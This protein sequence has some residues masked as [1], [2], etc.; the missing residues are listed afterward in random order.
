[1]TK[2]DQK[3]A[4]ELKHMTNGASGEESSSKEADGTDGAAPD[5]D[6]EFGFQRPDFMKERLAG[7]VRF[8]QRHVFL[9]YK[10]PAEWPSHVEATEFDRLPHLLADAVS[11]RQS[12]FKKI[13]KLTVCEGEAGTGSSLG[14]VLIF[15]DMIQYRG[16]THFDTER[17]VEEVLVKDTEWLSGSPEIMRGSHVFICAHGSR[18]KRSSVCGPAL[19]ARFRKD[20]ESQGLNGQVIVRACSHV[21]GHKY[22]GNVIIFSSD[23]NGKVTGHWYGYVAPDDVPELLRKHI[24][25]GEIVDHLWSIDSASNQ[26]SDDVIKSAWSVLYVMGQLGTCEEEPKNALVCARVD[27]LESVMQ[28]KLFIPAGFD[29]GAKLQYDKTHGFDT[30]QQLC[31]TINKANKYLSTKMAAALLTNAAIFAVESKVIKED[32]FK[33]KGAVCLLDGAAIPL[34]PRYDLYTSRNIVKPL[35]EREPEIAPFILKK[36]IPHRKKKQQQEDAEEEFHLE[37]SIEQSKK[38]HQPE[39]ATIPKKSTE[40][41]KKTEEQNE[42]EVSIRYCINRLEEMTE[43][44]R[45]EKAKAILVLKDAKNR[46]IF[47]TVGDSETM[48]TWLFLEIANM[49]IPER[50]KENGP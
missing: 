20:I 45:D 17:F 29:G 15:P 12:N 47:D 7:T 38:K 43:L 46:V 16:V 26:W 1:M 33:H 21:G 34:V 5:M 4:L 19:I 9:C 40:P 31:D 42:D 2:E 35:Q 11:A 41:S 14:D 27:E 37:K 48:K 25:E 50:G 10:S 23:V 49:K 30:A 6:A 18:D 39:D 28:G 13:T 32:K 36:S 44:T 3:K 8:H 24:V 22:A